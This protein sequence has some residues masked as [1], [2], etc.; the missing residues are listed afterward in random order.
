MDVLAL[1]AVQTAFQNSTDV[2]VVSAM[3]TH[4]EFTF[5]VLNTVM[6]LY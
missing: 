4:R 3:N 2:S 5:W 1:H 6:V